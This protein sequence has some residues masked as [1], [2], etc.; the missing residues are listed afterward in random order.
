MF[1]FGK[2]FRMEVEV[3]VSHFIPRRGSRETNN[4]TSDCL[5]ARNYVV[6][7]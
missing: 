5:Y 3:V 1:A 6:L 4:V 2:L 7:L